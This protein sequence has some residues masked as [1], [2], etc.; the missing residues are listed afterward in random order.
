MGQLLASADSRVQFARYAIAGAIVGLTYV[1]LTLLLSGPAGVPI[2][3]AIPPS[4]ATAVALHYVLQRVF[5]FGH[6]SRFVLSAREQIGR[7]VVIGLAQYAATSAS[8]GLLPDVLD[9]DEQVVY[10]GTVAVLSAVTFLLLRTRVF[11]GT[12]H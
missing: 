4:Y 12:A 3:V 11:H 8:T 1:G 2:L 7:Y 6:V 9:L 5:V 10:V